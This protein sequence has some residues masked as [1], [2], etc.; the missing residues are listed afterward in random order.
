M[1]VIVT[2]TTGGN[3]SLDFKAGSAII[4][5]NLAPAASV[6]IGD[7]ALLDEVNACEAVQAMIAA[8]QITVESA[9]DATDLGA[10][11]ESLT[12]GDYANAD[13]TASVLQADGV[14]PPIMICFRMIDQVTGHVKLVT[15]DQG[16][17][18]VS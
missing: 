9:Y 10:S 15:V 18:V 1:Q 13:N 7:R 11:Y 2:N 16:S 5:E 8:G 14:N 6:N 4:R 3:L 17:L 12:V